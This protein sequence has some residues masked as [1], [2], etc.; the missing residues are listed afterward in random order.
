[1]RENAVAE[2]DAI[3]TQL[4][5]GVTPERAAGA[6]AYL[7][8][9]LAFTGAS[10][11][12]A[13]AAVLGWRRSQPGLS[14]S[15]LLAVATEL[16]SRQ[17]FECRL[18][19]VIMLA[20]RRQLLRAEDLTV[21]EQLLRESR[22]WAL[23]D[24]LAADVAGSL[25]ERFPEL[26][27]TLD[28]WA[29]DEDFWIRRSALLALLVPLRRGNLADFPRFAGYADL[30][31]T[32]KEFF[33]RK[34]IGWVLRE[35]AKRHPDVVTAWLRPRVHRASGVTVREAVKYLPAADKDALLT[36]YQARTAVQP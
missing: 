9:D 27:A 22:T 13:R 5:T 7:K 4:R 3:H 15:H 24:S 18:A 10:V 29:L 17:V 23:V 14:R 30:M 19:A 35:T 31:L 26:L 6:K 8:L 21:V 2:A 1:M 28:R 32:E 36:A 34:A 33:I 25:V 16:W 12:Q 11:P 20:D